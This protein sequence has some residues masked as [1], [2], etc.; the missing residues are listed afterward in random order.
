MLISIKNSY[1]FKYFFIIVNYFTS[2][3]ISIEY[4][5]INNAPNN[6]TAIDAKNNSLERVDQ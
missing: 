5:T 2:R 4:E 6:F 1:R 3:F